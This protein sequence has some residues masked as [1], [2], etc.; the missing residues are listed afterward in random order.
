[1]IIIR[2]EHLNSFLVEQ[3]DVYGKIFGEHRK[4]R[5]NSRLVKFLHEGDDISHHN[6]SVKKTT[7]ISILS[8]EPRPGSHLSVLDSELQI[9]NAMNIE[10]VITA[11]FFSP[12]YTGTSRANKTLHINLSTVSVAYER[13]SYTELCFCDG[14]SIFIENHKELAFN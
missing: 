1:M 10:S 7:I 9:L 3:A 4:A 5:I 2:T 6:T 14:D 11:R 8:A 12:K 13:G